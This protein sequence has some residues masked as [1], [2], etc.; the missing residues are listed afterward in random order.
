MEPALG[1]T[2]TRNERGVRAVLDGA[3]GSWASGGRVSEGLAEERTATQRWE[4]VW[5]AREV[6]GQSSSPGLGWA[7]PACERG[8]ACRP[9]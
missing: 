2:G 4:A 3:E 1:G 5:G 6:W 8:Q 9:L 7:E